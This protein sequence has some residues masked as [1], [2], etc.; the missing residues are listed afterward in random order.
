[1]RM[2]HAIIGSTV[3]LLSACGVPERDTGYTPPVEPIA[4]ITPFSSEINSGQL[5]GIWVNA[6]KHTPIVLIVPGSG[7]TSKDGNGLGFV[8]NSYKSLA[9]ELAKSGISSVRVDKRG[10]FSSAKAG[11]PNQVTIE[12]YTQDYR[13]WVQTIIDKTG[14]SCV[15]LLGHSEG[16]IMVASAAIDQTQVCGVLNVAAPGFPLGEIFR[17]QFKNN[18]A[19]APIL[20]DALSVIDKLEAGEKADV[21]G[22]HPALQQIFSPLVQDYLISAFSY[23]P[24]ELLA[25]VNPPKIVIQG[26]HDIQVSEEDA[27]RLAEIG[28]AELVILDGISHVLKPGSKD[29]QANIMSYNS[30]DTPVDASV[31]KAVA[32]FIQTHKHTSYD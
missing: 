8:A 29:M 13:D 4:P 26:S 14:Q 17:K 23:D 15:F 1:M 10:L 2:K 11:D 27:K 18:P 16:G 24:A 28:R 12:L 3:I 22:L 6:G 21:T 19:N 31:V 25:K 30:P 9:E 32:D 20:A 7:P 5:G